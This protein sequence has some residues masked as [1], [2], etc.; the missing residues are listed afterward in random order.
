MSIPSWNPS[1]Q[2]AKN[3]ECIRS[4][5]RIIITSFRPNR[6]R[7]IF[8]DFRSSISAMYHS[9]THWTDGWS[10]WWIFSEPSS[11]LFYS[12]RSCCLQQ[13]LSRRHQKDRWFSSRSV[14][15]FTT[16]HFICINSDQ[17]LC[18]IKQQRKESGPSR[19][20]RAWHRSAN[21]WE[22]QA[23][24]NFRS[25][26]MS[27]RWDEPCGTKTGTTVF[28]EKFKEEIPRYMVKHQVR[29]GI[30]GWAQING[31]RGGHFYYEANRIWTC[32][33]LKLDYRVG[34]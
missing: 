15:D 25:C 6:T 32:I 18:R 21:L 29:P 10:D 12:L 7:R 14:W 26:S 22:R 8:W 31:Y 9:A 28:V 27:W 34:Y 16:D 17:W 23:S 24:T 19:M 33:I 4:L 1:L 11:Q 3:Q 5:F 2:C 30:T 13:F 20:I